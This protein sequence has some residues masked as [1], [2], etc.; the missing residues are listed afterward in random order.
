MNIIVMDESGKWRKWIVE[1]LEGAGHDVVG[2]SGSAEFMEAIDRSE[3]DKILLDVATWRRGAAIYRYF[4]FGKR[5]A[6]IPV[7]FYNAPESFLGIPERGQH[8]DD[9]VLSKADDVEVFLKAV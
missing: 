2:C 6:G 1:T 5:I 9:K 7:L 4:K 8:P 3:W